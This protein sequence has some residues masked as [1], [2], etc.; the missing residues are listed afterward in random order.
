MNREYDLIRFEKASDFNMRKFDASKKT[1]RKLTE[2]PTW[3]H[4]NRVATILYQVGADEDTI[5][6]G[7]VHDTL[8]D[9]E[10]TY[11]ELV[12]NFGENVARLVYAVTEKDRSLPWRERKQ[13]ARAEIVTM[14]E[15][16]QLL[17]TADL[18]DNITDFII[19]YPDRGDSMFEIFNAGK[20]NQY[21]RFR[22]LAET[23]RNTWSDNPLLPEFEK[24]IQHYEIVVMGI[25]PNS[26]A[27]EHF[28]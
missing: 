6:A 20:T 16:E 2:Q 15:D 18:I 4:S 12:K 5:V 7:Y 17:K 26:Y 1:K 24:A 22:K 27:V 19:S 8:E 3:I 21:D 14:S 28:A 25:R 13:R 11:E 23:L 10:T 9:T